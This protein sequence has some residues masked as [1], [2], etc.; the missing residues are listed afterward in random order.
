[1]F[2]NKT[3]SICLIVL[4]CVAALLISGCTAS[5]NPGIQPITT[6]ADFIGFITELHPLQGQISVESDA[7]KIVTKYTVSIKNETLIF[8]QDGNN[9]RKAAFSDFKNKQWVQIWFTGPILESWPMQ[10]TAQ[11]VV[12][13]E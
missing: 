3:S 2:K 4:A 5:N 7:D 1:M 13:T 9:L 11:Q 8:R 6:K 12:I 10:G